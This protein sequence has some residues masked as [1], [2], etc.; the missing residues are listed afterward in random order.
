MKKIKV[1]VPLGPLVGKQNILEVRVWQKLARLRGEA[2]KMSGKEGGENW[3]VNSVNCVTGE[4]G[5]QQQN[6]EGGP[7]FPLSMFTR[8]FLKVPR[9]SRLSLLD[10]TNTNTTDKTNI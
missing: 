7:R 2:H 10:L 5:S 9:I 1:Q 3:R 8:V 4:G 6:I